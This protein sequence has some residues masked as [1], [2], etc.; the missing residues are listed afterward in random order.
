MSPAVL[1][2]VTLIIQFAMAVGPEIVQEAQLALSLLTSTTEITPEQE[3]QV[4]AALNAMHQKL[5]SAQASS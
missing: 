1:Q 5:Q 3:Q 4:R 2:L